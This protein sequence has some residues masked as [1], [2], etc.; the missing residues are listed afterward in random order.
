MDSIHC[1]MV[2]EWYLKTRGPKIPTVEK[3]RLNHYPKPTLRCIQ[4][5]V[6]VKD[7]K[8]FLSKQKK[9]ELARWQHD[10][11]FNNAAVVSNNLLRR[12]FTNALSLKGIAC[13]LIVKLHGKFPIPEAVVWSCS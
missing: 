12:I 1:S 4:S 9:A 6:L 2:L 8:R 13:L 11:T 7:S 10:D 3:Y 5:F